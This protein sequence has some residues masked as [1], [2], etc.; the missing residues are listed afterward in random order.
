MRDADGFV[1]LTGPADKT[2]RLSGLTLKVKRGPGALQ[3]DTE[4]LSL[5]TASRA[6]AFLENLDYTRHSAGVSRV[7]SRAQ[8]EERLEAHLRERGAARTGS[9]GFAT[10]PAG[11][12]RFSMHPQV[13]RVW[14]RSSVRCFRA[15]PTSSS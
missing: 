9:T 12:H 2:E 8:I 13:S 4:F 15:D 3:G 11:S 10:M 1:F 7:L 14:S 5:Y 6:R